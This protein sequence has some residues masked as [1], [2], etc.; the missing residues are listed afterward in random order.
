MFQVI[1]SKNADKHKKLLKQAS[2]DNRAKTLLELVAHNPFQ[3][4]PSYEKLL[5]DFKGAYSR[6]I[7]HQHR[8]VYTVDEQNHIVH[9]LSM[10]THYE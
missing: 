6:H 10:W 4:P 7:N 8:F 2:L 1:F 3:N 9:I 5:G